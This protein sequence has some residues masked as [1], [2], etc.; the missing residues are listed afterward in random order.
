MNSQVGWILVGLGVT[1][2]IV[3]LILVFAPSIPRLGRLP[4][5]IVIEHDRTRIFLPITTS[6]VISVLLSLLLTGIAWLVRFFSRS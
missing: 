2:A 3:G 1:I 4:G 6:I 5:D